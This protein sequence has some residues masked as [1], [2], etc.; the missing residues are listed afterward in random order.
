MRRTILR[1]RALG[2]EKKMVFLDAFASSRLLFQAGTWFGCTAANVRALAAPYTDALRAATGNSSF[3][4]SGVSNLVVRRAASR[5]DMTAQLR[6]ARLAF[7]PRVLRS[8]PP[9]LLG[10]LDFQLSL[11]RGWAAQLTDDLD[12]VADLILQCDVEEGMLGLLDRGLWDVMAFAFASPKRWKGFVKRVLRK[13]ALAAEASDIRG[14]QA[15]DD[16]SSDSDAIRHFCYECGFQA[17]TAKG[18]KVHMRRAH[19]LRLPGASFALESGVCESCHTCY[20]TRPRLIRHLNHACK[21]CLVWYQD[22]CEPLS[23]EE[24]VRLDG[25]DSANRKSLQAIG[26]REDRSVRPPVQ[27]FGPW[28][29]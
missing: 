9:H 10:I 20:W 11:Q 22:H 3:D 2:I 25:I 12:W 17:R 14:I 8:A 7:L 4:D 19:D 1:R 6:C 16:I 28:R 15:S 27:V 5:I 13:H 29:Q 24:I 21:R 23:A 26:L 18:L